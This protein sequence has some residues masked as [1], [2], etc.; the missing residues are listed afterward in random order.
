MGIYL[1]V[2]LGALQGITEFLPVSSS[3]H[4]V[5]VQSI[6]PGF[7]QAGVVFDAILHA[8]TVLAVL[9][10]FRKTLLRMKRNYL[11]LLAIGTIPAAVIGVLFQDHI[12]V[13]E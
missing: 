1:A 5:L 13:Q 8:G 12:H 3:G 11:W 10:Y 4:L 7:T 9:I 2:V 6:M